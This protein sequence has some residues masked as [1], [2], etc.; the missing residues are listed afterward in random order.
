VRPGGLTAAAR[1][2]NDGSSPGESAG[3][4]ATSKG[5]EAGSFAPPPCDGFALRRAQLRLLVLPV[6]D[7]YIRRQLSRTRDGPSSAPQ[8]LGPDIRATLD[9]QTLADP[10]A[11]AHGQRVRCSSMGAI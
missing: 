5:S 9:F 1:C 11:A 2:E 3:N 7:V 6:P 10:K 8:I 4:P